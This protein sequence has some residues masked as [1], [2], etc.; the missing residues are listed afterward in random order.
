[1]AWVARGPA[2]YPLDTRGRAQPRVRA[3]PPRLASTGLAS[4]EAALHGEYDV[5]VVGAGIG[6]LCAAAVLTQVYGKRVAVCEAH[7]LAGGCAHAFERRGADGT[8]YL[9][10]SGPTIVLGCSA[11]PYNPLR[12]VL[13]AVGQ[14]E[15]VQWIRY[16]GWGM[17]VPPSEAPATLPTPGAWKLRLGPGH[18]QEGPLSMFGGAGAVGEFEALRVACA[19]LVTAA[20]DIPAMA[21]RGDRWSLLPL[22]RHFEALKTLAGQV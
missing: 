20:A 2:A 3:F 19:P 8:P 6:G 7:Y 4:T 12:Q 5:A 1:M 13:N 18:F 22:L 14:G 11:P 21:M 16:D 10:D 17:L 15:A 9:F